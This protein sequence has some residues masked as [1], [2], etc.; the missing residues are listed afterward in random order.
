MDVEHARQL[1]I[2]HLAS[3]IELEFYGDN[4]WPG[5]VYQSS[6]EYLVFI[7]L[8]HGGNHIGATRCVGV[9][10]RPGGKI[11]VEFVGE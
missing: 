9:P 10:K 7:D 1:A 8:S 3:F 5:T 6:E 4:V 2:E 11:R